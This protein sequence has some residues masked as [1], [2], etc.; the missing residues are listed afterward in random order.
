MLTW[1]RKRVVE[2]NMTDP[3][4]NGRGR[5]LKRCLAIAGLLALFSLHAGAKPIGTFSLGVQTGWSLG[6]GEN[7]GMHYSIEGDIPHPYIYGVRLYYHLGGHVRYDVS[8]RFGLQFNMSFQKG[9][10]T[11]THLLHSP[12]DW[13]SYTRG[14]SFY[15]YGLN[16]IFYFPKRRN[17]RFYF[18]AGA[19]IGDSWNWIYG[20]DSF[21][22]FTFGGG[23]KIPLG[24]GARS[25]L[26]LE[27]SFN[28]LFDPSENSKIDSMSGL[29]FRFTLGFEINL[30][31][32][33]IKP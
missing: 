10:Y 16:G 26:N 15:S 32:K 30:N 23:G 12:N 25:A 13:V 17:V 29:F 31:S 27:L 22:I 19:G 18:L 20:Y 21:Y 24:P 14:S 1:R 2:S 6:V 33:K 4:K 5:H 28:H 7:L 8:D 11:D 3:S 9:T